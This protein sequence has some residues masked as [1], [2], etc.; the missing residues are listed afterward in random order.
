MSI[1]G[2]APLPPTGSGNTEIDRI[3][4]IVAAYFPVYETRVTPQ[5]LLL[6]VH[7]DPPTLEAKFDQLRQELTRR[8]YIGAIR[9]DK[10][11]YFLEIARRPPIRP[12]GFWVNLAL[13]VATFVTTVFAGAF[14]WLAYVGQ[15]TLTLADFANGA[16]YF[17]APVM[18]ILGLHELAHYVMARRHHVAASLP[19][20]VPVPPPYL[21]FGTFG[22][23]ISIRE[24]IPD[25]KTLLDIGASGPIAGF[26]VSI[27]IAIAG[28]FLSAHSSPPAL[29]ACGPVILGVPYG[30]LLFGTS[31]FW[32]FLALFIPGA[33]QNLHPLAIAGWVGILVTAINLLPAGQLDGGH[34]FR[35]LFGDRARYVSYAAVLLLFGLGLIF[36]YTGWFIFA[37]LILLLGVRHPPPLN[38][39]SRLDV[40]RYAVGGL[41]LAILIT[42]FV[43][44][45]IST[46]LGSIGIPSAGSVH[47][48]IPAGYQMADNLTLNFTN[49]DPVPHGFLFSTSISS[50][51]TTVNNQTMPLNGT[52]LARFIANSSW[53]F[54]LPSGVVT[55]AANAGN[56]TIPSD[57][58]SAVDGGA[59][60]RLI[61]TYLNRQ[62]GA[63]TITITVSVICPP[64]GATPVSATFTA[65]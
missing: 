63:V 18:T 29:S 39:I 53:I 12:Y 33:N 9:Y 45:P 17:A 35:A 24:P 44:V 3:R 55:T 62:Q 36:F 28:M 40:K 14:I 32:D 19:Y 26:A 56:V 37:I 54:Y 34:V 21:I 13:L 11:E 59:H 30:N 52:A 43:V 25:K 48:P 6:V 41:A 8:D 46:P 64:S 51:T 5:S 27:P 23:F 60:G 58:Y 1:P 10:G 49:Q 16:L 7:V 22:A 4:S 61:A 20:F 31:L 42:G 57:L 15:T 47:V 2:G 38:D 50:V 65:S